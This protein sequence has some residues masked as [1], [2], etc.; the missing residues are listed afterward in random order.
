MSVVSLSDGFKIPR[1]GFGTYKLNGFSGAQAISSA[2]TVGYR[3]IDTAYNYQN[4][5][6]VGRGIKAS[7]VPRNEL[8][9][10]SK[11]PGKYYA[12]EQATIA[13]VQESLY[14]TGLDYFDL[15]LLHWPNPIDDHY[16]TAWQTLIQLQ[17][18]G[19]VKSIGVSNFLPEHIER[20]QRETG[21]L[22]VVNQI[23][24]HPYFNQKEMIQYNTEKNILTQAW[25]PLG[26]A[27]R[28]LK[29]NL[30]LELAEKYHK[31]VGQIILRWETQQGVV[32]IPKAVSYTRQVGNLNVFD[33]ELESAE[34]LAIDRLS[35]KDGRTNNQ[36]PAVY[37]EF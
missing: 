15:Y 34:M 21:V 36:D 23:E 28:L 5:G 16:L 1:I 17:K 19:L 3:L 27:S 10:Q 2:L 25:S 24:L 6:T 11:L 30:L 37:Q 22:P 32:P 35:K 4:E 20:L 14:R 26:R 12:D 13:L 33:F 9:I 7:M 18:F 8:F 29:D 31:N